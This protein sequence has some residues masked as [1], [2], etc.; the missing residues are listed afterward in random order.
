MTL[1]IGSKTLENAHKLQWAKMRLNSRYGSLSGI[2]YRLPAR[3][4]R[5]LKRRDDMDKASI[6][7]RLFG[8]RPT[9]AEPLPGAAAL[10]YPSSAVVRLYRRSDAAAITTTGQK[11]LQKLLKKYGARNR[12]GDFR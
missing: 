7:V 3:L 4:R 6:W 11:R 9:K 5:S 2:N 12:K 1:Q 10:D 8:E